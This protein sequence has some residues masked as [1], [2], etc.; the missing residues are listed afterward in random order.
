MARP[1][2]AVGSHFIN[3]CV[4]SILELSKHFE[5]IMYINI[6]VEH[7]LGVE[8]AFYTTDRVLTMSFH[9]ESPS[10]GHSEDMGD[11]LGKGYSVNVPFLDGI[12]DATFIPVFMQFVNHAFMV[13]SPQVR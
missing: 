3:D 1:N 2:S 7:A 13:Y 6:D 12:D 10:S 9:H 8:E 4:L 11:D 5:R